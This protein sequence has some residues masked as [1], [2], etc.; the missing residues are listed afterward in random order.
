MNALHYSRWSDNIAISCKSTIPLRLPLTRV[1][2]WKKRLWILFVFPRGCF[3]I[4]FFPD[5][6]L[7]FAKSRLFYWKITRGGV[8][9]I[10]ISSSGGFSN[11]LI[12]I[13]ADWQSMDGS[14]RKPGKNW[15]K[16]EK[17]MA[18]RLLAGQRFIYDKTRGLIARVAIGRR[19]WGCGDQNDE[20]E[21]YAKPIEIMCVCVCFPAHSNYTPSLV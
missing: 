14:R 19:A 9:A 3:F 11:F 10:S 7:I 4:P 8:H 15:G 18:P 6:Q 17:S 2:E 16:S 1:R 21:A 5:T 12:W 13:L 20:Y